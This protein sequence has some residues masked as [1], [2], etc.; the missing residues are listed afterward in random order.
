[1]DIHGFGITNKIM[2]P[3]LLEQ[4]ITTPNLSWVLDEQFKEF[5][6][7]GRQIQIAVVTGDTAFIDVQAQ[8]GVAVNL[9]RQ[10][11]NLLGTAQ[12]S[13]AAEAAG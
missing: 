13:P 8:V 12:Q 5:V 1:M 4:L 6:L 11:G 7:L 2:P 3:D 9:L 10:G